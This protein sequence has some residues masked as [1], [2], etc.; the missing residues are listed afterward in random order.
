MSNRFDPTQLRDPNQVLRPEL[1]RVIGSGIKVGFIAQ[2]AGVHEKTVSGINS[3]RRR[4]VT[5]AVHELIL[6]ALIKIEQG[7][8]EI[9]TSARRP[10]NR[11]VIQVQN[12]THCGYG[13]EL[14]ED[15]TRHLPAESGKVK[16]VCKECESRRSRDYRIRK[17]REQER[18]VTPQ[19]P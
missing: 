17:I 1:H 10:A 16:R 19:T 11:R 5:I 8:V 7:E 12:G 6:D 3:G 2:M 4:T 15:N 9:P 13:H 14:T 18:S